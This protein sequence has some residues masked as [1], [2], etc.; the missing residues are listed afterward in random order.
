[1]GIRIGTVFTG[2]VDQVGEQSV[3]TKFFMIGVPLIPLESFY[4]L[5][6]DVNG[7]NGFRI[8]L[9]GKSVLMAYARWGSFIGAVIAGIN[10]MV[11]SS[12]RRTAADWIPLGLCLAAWVFFTF[13]TT[14]PNKRE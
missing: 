2:T 10:A 4:V 14:A 7:V 6:E 5:R 3:Q 12:W 8:E 11:T 1:M 9:S 13:F